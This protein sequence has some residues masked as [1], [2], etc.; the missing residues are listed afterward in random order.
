M[1]RGIVMGV[2]VAA[3]EGYLYWRYRAL[4]AQFHFWLHGLLGAALAAFVLT[5]VGL[6]RRRPAR[7]VWR[8]GLAGHAYSAG[9]DLVFLTLGVV[10]ELWMDVFAFHITLHLIPAPLATMFAVFALSLVGWAATTLG[11]WR[12]AALLAGTAVAV[13]VAAF[14]LRT[15]LPRTLEDVRADPG[16]ALICPLAATPPTA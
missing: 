8:A 10:H 6:V 14:A 5:V 1:T 16:L 2:V 15:P 13:T 11:R 4:G 3:V 12:A 9:P 7:P